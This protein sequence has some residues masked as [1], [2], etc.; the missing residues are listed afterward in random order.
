[1]GEAFSALDVDKDGFITRG[2]IKAFLN[3]SDENY[4]GCLIEDA[5]DDCDGGLTLGEFQ[6]V[7]A[8][9]IKGESEEMQKLRKE[10]QQ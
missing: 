4:I 2:D 1:V 3:I 10:M 5:D 7:M 6:R 9:V 8:M